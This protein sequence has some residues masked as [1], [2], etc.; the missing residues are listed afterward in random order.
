VTKTTCRE[1]VWTAIRHQQPDRVPWQFNYTTPAREKL[2]AH[3]GTRD[4]DRLLGNH[5]AKYRARPADGLVEIRPGFW[6][7]EYGVVWNR[8]I[9]RD[10][11][12]VET[13]LIRERTLAGYRFPDPKDRTRYT[14]LPAFLEAHPDRF[15]YVSI[16][17]SLFERAWSLRGMEALMID[18][19]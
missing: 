3:F 16:A 11:G 10:I 9:D 12:V 18:M 1:R 8:T 2:E 6:R 5:L 14:S 7:D 4:L 13:Y 19:V 15:R 17:Y